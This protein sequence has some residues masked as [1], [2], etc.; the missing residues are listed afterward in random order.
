MENG[1]PHS[2]SENP[3]R[4]SSW[5]RKLTATVLS[6]MTIAAS[7]NL[8]R[9][10][11][12]TISP[13]ESLSSEQAEKGRNLDIDN[14]KPGDKISFSANT[15]IVDSALLNVR[16]QPKVVEEEADGSS[17]R[18]NLDGHKFT[19][20]NPV[21]V[22]ADINGTWWL[23]LD[24]KGREYYFTGN[25]GGLTNTNGDDISITSANNNG[26]VVAVTNKGN[27][28]EDGEGNKSIIAAVAKGES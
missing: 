13:A 24:A 23:V 19:A 5:Q 21:K 26:T 1:I 7:I 27:V 11:T 3:D 14:L 2:R 16:H 17:N 25:N 6:A 4:R 12:D 9:S 22:G 20:V 10:D 18:W 8:M 15:I 28:A